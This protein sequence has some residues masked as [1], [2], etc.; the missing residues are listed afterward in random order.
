MVEIERAEKGKIVKGAGKG[1]KIT[2]LSSLAKLRIE[3]L[4]QN[5]G[6]LRTERDAWIRDA[7]ERFG[8]L[9]VL[10]DYK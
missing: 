10:R 2:V 9:V 3:E 4:T 5:V 1:G 7:H 6:R 8:V